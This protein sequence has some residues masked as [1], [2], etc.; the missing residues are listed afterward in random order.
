MAQDKPEM[1]TVAGRPTKIAN[2]T[3]ADGVLV[4][5]RLPTGEDVYV[6]LKELFSLVE[7]DLIAKIRQS[8]QKGGTA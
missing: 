1:T 6:P 2:I 3:S 7:K 8:G 4:Q 5:C